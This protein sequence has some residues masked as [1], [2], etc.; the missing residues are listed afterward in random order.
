[1][2][3]SHREYAEW[4]PERIVRW[5]NKTGE[6]TRKLIE[7]VLAGRPHP[8][9]GFRTSLGILRLQT[10]YGA[11]RLEA[12]CQRALAIQSFTYKSVESI[13]KN[14]LDQIPLPQQ[15]TNSPPIE[16]QNVRGP[17][18]YQGIN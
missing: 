15:Q 11:Q 12:A 1:M 6:N 7:G 2:P 14:G 13:L 18:Y 9:Q 10:P 5:A 3:K 4:T 16:H 17:E 8:Q